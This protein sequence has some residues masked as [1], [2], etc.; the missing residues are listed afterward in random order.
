MTKAA[1]VGAVFALLALSACSPPPSRE[2]LKSCQDIARQRGAGKGLTQND[3]GELTEACMV[4][5]G[6]SLNR[7]SEQCRHDLISETANRCYYRN[8]LIGRIAHELSHL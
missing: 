5:K 8:D 2:T 6:Y 4:A 3:L 7:D 1:G